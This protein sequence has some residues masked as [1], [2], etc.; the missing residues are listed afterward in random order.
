MCP[1][2]QLGRPMAM[3]KK[4]VTGKFAR[5]ILRLQ[6][7][8]FNISHIKG[9][10]NCVADSL[11]RDPVGESAPE[12]VVCILTSNKPLGYSAEELAFQQR[13]DPQ[14]KSIFA[15]FGRGLTGSRKERE[16]FAVSGG[17]LYRK[18]PSGKGRSFLLCVPKSLRRLI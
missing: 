3:R 6:Q 4:E 1:N 12:H 2:G 10:E 14:F 5:W 9:I 7:F 16:T 18:N 8:D 11:S 13:L 17:V 15:N